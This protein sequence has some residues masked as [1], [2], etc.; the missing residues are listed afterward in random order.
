MAVIFKGYKQIMALLKN[1]G[2]LVYFEVP[3]QIFRLYK[4]S[5][6]KNAQLWFL[7]HSRRNNSNIPT[8]S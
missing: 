2:S 6:E 7:T 5:N 3:I 4:Q 1:I 8:T